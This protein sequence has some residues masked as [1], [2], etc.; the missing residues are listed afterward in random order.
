VDGGGF[1]LVI[2]VNNT[3]LAVPTSTAQVLSGLYFDISPS[4]GG[5]A[6]KSAVADL[7]MITD[8]PIGHHNTPASGTA[9]RFMCASLGALSAPNPDPACTVAGGWEAAY[10]TPAGLGGGAPIPA[11]QHWGIGTTGQGGIFHGGSANA[12]AFEY[13]IAPGGSTGI[14]LGSG[15]NGGLGNAFPIGYVYGKATFVLTG[16]SSEA[17]TIS[18]VNSAYGTQP[19]GTPAAQLITG[20]PPSSPSETPEPA[21]AG[22]LA[23]GAM[24]LAFARL[25]RR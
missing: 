17:I 21:T 15:G 3:A 1:D 24:L 13:G 7:G 9:G 11:Q 20:P 4:P 10:Q 14:T 8:S 5:L 18:N 12:G 25:C 2:V 6:M 22:M 16:L 19:E 23:G